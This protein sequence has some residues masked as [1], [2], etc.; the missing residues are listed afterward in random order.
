MIAISTMPICHVGS[1]IQLSMIT[2][3][4]IASTGTTTTQKNQ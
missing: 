1:G 2:A 4:A 3:P